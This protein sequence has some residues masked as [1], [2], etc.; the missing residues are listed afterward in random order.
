VAAINEY[1]GSVRYDYQYPK[2]SF[3]RNDVDLPDELHLAWAKERFS[4][5]MSCAPRKP[6]MGGA[7]SQPEP[8]AVI[9]TGFNNRRQLRGSRCT[10]LPPAI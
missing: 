5:L 9:P 4:D 3:G 2:G 7:V 8:S 6:T 1:G 10:T